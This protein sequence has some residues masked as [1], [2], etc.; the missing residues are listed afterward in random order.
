M[1]IRNS[2]RRRGFY[3]RIGKSEINERM[4]NS[5]T[6]RTKFAVV[7]RRP[8]LGLALLTVACLGVEHPSSTTPVVDA[9]PDIRA[10]TG[11]SLT[12]RADVGNASGSFDLRKYSI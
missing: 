1:D 7:V 11:Q 3:S 2:T 12:L 5:L 10:V 4:M 8:G 9:G 6:S